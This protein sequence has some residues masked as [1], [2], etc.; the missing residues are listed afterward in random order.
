MNR[1]QEGATMKRLSISVGA[2]A[3]ATVWTAGPGTAETVR[4]KAERTGQ[5]VENTADRVEDK[6]E[7]KMDRLKDKARETKD[8]IKEKAAEAK[9]KLAG[10]ADRAG[11]KLEAKVDGRDVRAGQQ[12]LRDH[13]Y[14][15]G[16]IDGVHGP[17]TAAAIRR[18]QQA[19]GLTVTGRFDD[20][21]M[22][23]LNGPHPMPSA[24]P[25]TERALDAPA[26]P[27]TSLEQSPAVQGTTPS[28]TTPAGKRQ[29]P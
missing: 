6:T 1:G 26:P 16:P 15:P 10:K 28:P 19:E 21:T 2:V 13:G 3:L 17:R 23:R 27:A 25:A 22:A 20:A 18:Y 24:S 5:R 4:D 8:T 11:D 7:S 14:D 29:T 12:A 9:D